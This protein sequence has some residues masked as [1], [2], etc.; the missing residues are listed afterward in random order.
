MSRSWETEYVYIYACAPITASSTDDRFLVDIMSRSQCTPC[1]DLFFVL[2]AVARLLQFLNCFF[3]MKRGCSAT[4]QPVISLHI[5][6]CLNFA[7]LLSQNKSFFD[8]SFDEKVTNLP[9]RDVRRVRG[10]WV[11]P[12]TRN[13]KKILL[14]SRERKCVS[15]ALRVYR[16]WSRVKILNLAQMTAVTCAA[17]FGSTAPNWTNTWALTTNHMAVSARHTY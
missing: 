17:Y 7:F 12:T 14:A 13:R 9:K 4:S 11:S 15:P 5:F 16:A 10:G 1:C 2:T 8:Y 3:T 6:I